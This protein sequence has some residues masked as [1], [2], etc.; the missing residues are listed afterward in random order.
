MN[1]RAKS[2]LS[3]SLDIVLFLFLGSFQELTKKELSNLYF[4]SA[5]LKER[6][7]DF[8]VTKEVLIVL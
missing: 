5:L 3:I 4:Q 7:K 1:V 2:I 6:V 8:K